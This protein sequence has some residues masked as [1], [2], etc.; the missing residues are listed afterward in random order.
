MSDDE[1][2][3]G[4]VAVPGKARPKREP[5]L[6]RWVD[7]LSEIS[8]YLSGACIVVAMLVICY[9][10][11]L[12]AMGVSTIWQTELA[13]Y[14]LIF[15]TF[16]GGAYGLKQGSHVSVELLTSRLPAKG[17]L[18]LQVVAGLLSLVLIAAVGWY[19]YQMW[20]EAIES[21]ERSGTAWNP[22]LSI[23]YLI[24]PVGM[25]LI[26]LQYLVL[27]ARSIQELRNLREAGPLR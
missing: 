23:P 24:L 2:L 13:T 18:A 26:A 21:G 8:G 20:W 27:I 10:V 11:V 19:S 14:L 3:R 9:A 4:D 7:T 16:V 17:R 5:F 25:V 12:R 6:M 1:Q 22:S 15:V